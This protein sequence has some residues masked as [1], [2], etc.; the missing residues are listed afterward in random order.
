[1]LVPCQVILFTL[2]LGNAMCVCGA[3]VQLGGLL[4]VLEM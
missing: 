4:V 2:L 3:V 1:M